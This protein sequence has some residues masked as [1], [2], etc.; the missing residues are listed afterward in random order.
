MSVHN[1][2]PNHLAFVRHLG[3]FTISVNQWTGK[4]Q[5]VNEANGDGAS[6]AR[7]EQA[8]AAALSLH[9]SAVDQRNHQLLGA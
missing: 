2:K 6:F 4:F 7:L 3:P 9:Q 8:T 1:L 5:L